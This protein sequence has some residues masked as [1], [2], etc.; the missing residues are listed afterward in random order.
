MNTVNTKT[1]KIP[2]D[3]IVPYDEENL[4]VYCTKNVALIL[5][6]IRDDKGGIFSIKEFML[7]QTVFACKDFRKRCDEFIEIMGARLERYFDTKKAEYIFFDEEEQA[8]LKTLFTKHTLFCD[9]VVS[10]RNEEGRMEVMTFDEMIEREIPYVKVGKYLEGLGV[11][12][13][14]SPRKFWMEM[15]RYKEKREDVKSKME[16]ILNR[17]EKKVVDT[18]LKKYPIFNVKTKQEFS[19]RYKKAAKKFHPDVNPAGAEIFKTL[20]EDMDEIKKTRWYSELEGE[21]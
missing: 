14:M 4:I 3:K 7:S 11:R 8:A 10:I 16:E 9:V 15:G 6:N 17:K 19:A 18:F 13:E 1:S 5:K 21:G 12:Y 20:L 2:F